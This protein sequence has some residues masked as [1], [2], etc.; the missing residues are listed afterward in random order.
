MFKEKDN[1]SSFIKGLGLDL[2]D[3]KGKVV[4]LVEESYADNSFCLS[5]FMW[6]ALSTQDKGVCIL[7]LHHSLRHYYHVGMRL[8]YNLSTAFGTR[9]V[10][11]DAV[12]IKEA[13]AK[14]GKKDELNA[15]LVFSLVREKMIFLKKQCKQIFL[16]IDD[17]SDFLNL[18]VPLREVQLFIHYV[19]I[20][21]KNHSTI[22]ISTHCNEDDSEQTNIKNTLMHISDLRLVIRNLET[23]FSKEVTGSIEV[24]VATDDRIQGW[25]QPILYHYKTK[26]R[27]INVFL[28]GNISFSY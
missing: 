9:F 25:S 12:D 3:F 21:F 16:L 27:S 6:L 20:H 23:G 2:F 26:D 28:P 22:I 5:C 4:S 18:G 13:H 7:T 17:V 19:L 10:A 15:K 8:G 14:A 11:V 24:S 1:M